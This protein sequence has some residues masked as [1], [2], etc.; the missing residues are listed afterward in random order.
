MAKIQREKIPSLIWSVFSSSFLCISRHKI[1][2]NCDARLKRGT[3]TS[4][5]IL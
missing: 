3:D 4:L 2:L 5:T 1:K